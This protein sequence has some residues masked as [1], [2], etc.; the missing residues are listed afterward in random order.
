MGRYREYGHAE[1]W[2]TPENLKKPKTYAAA[3]AKPNRQKP[4]KYGLLASMT[5]PTHTIIVSSDAPTTR[6]NKLVKAI[7][8]WLTPEMGVGVDRGQNSHITGGLEWEK[9]VARVRYRKRA[10]NLLCHP[11]LE[12]SPAIPPASLKPATYM[13]GCSSVW[14]QSPS[15]VLALPR[16]RPQQNIAEKTKCAHCE[17]TTGAYAKLN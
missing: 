15:T 6:V 8:R 1:R 2:K 10:G 9:I 13:W 3:A 4:L 7:R 11:V 12:V 17:A 14:D 16:I 5:T